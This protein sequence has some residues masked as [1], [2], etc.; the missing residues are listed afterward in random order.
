MCLNNSCFASHGRTQLDS[1][2]ILARRKS[3]VACI[4]SVYNF[5]IEIVLAVSPRQAEE[6]SDGATIVVQRR[7]HSA[8][9]AR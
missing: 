7:F 5:K 1:R 8:S 6:T 3:L 9:I 2:D 4:S